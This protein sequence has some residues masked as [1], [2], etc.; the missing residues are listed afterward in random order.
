MS[1]IEYREEELLLISGIQ[2]F[3]F[4]RRQWG[5]IHLE[6]IW[7]ENPLTLEGKFLHERVDDPYF[8]E[9]R[10]DLLIVRALP[11]HSYTLGISGICD[12]VEFR[13]SEDG[14]KLNGHSGTYLP[15][16]VEYK[17]G[18]DKRDH[19]DKLQLL[20]EAI[21][22]EEMLACRIETGY[23]YYNK[24]RRRTKVYFDEALRAELI[25]IVNEMHG[26][27][28]RKYTP[29]AKKQK[30]CDACS[31]KDLCL[32]QLF[33]KESVEHYVLRRLKE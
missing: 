20:A 16:P 4:C 19:A 2:H 21:C 14:I 18:T 28:K 31:L 30:K 23:L 8:T 22:L 15:T 5:L 12:V 27:A 9:K 24:K 25:Q 33:E 26:Y 7:Q 10:K 29:K 32:P 1:P 13:R 11:V 6:D 3:T 17:R